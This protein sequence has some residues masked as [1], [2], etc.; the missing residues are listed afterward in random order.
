MTFDNNTRYYP[1]VAL[2]FL[3]TSW[4]DKKG[5]WSQIKYARRVGKCVYFCENRRYD[6]GFCF[7][8]P[9]AWDEL[10]RY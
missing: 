5:R 9:G 8:T 1:G 2:R 4:N 7:K 10:V 6:K 3:M